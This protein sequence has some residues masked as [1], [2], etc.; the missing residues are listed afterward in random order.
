LVYWL[1]IIKIKIAAKTWFT[2]ANKIKD[3]SKSWFTIT[4]ITSFFYNRTGKVFS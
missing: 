1:V 4:F 3:S 2:G